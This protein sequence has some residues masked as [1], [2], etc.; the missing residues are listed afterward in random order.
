M[1]VAFHPPPARAIQMPRVAMHPIPWGCPPAGQLTH[2][3][4]LVGRV[5]VSAFANAREDHNDC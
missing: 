2:G 5:P 1:T 3:A 4:R